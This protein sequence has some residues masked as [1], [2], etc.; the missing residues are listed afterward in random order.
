MALGLPRRGSPPQSSTQSP[1]RCRERSKQA[2]KWWYRLGCFVILDD[3][4]RRSR[5]QKIKTKNYAEM[6]KQEEHQLFPCPLAPT[7]NSIIG[8]KGFEK[9]QTTH[10]LRRCCSPTTKIPQS[11]GLH[12]PFSL[13]S[14][15]TAALSHLPARHGSMREW[16]VPRTI[17]LDAHFIIQKRMRASLPVDGMRTR[18]G[19]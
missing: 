3:R 8:D 2:R 17:M 9:G 16:V 13:I 1:L 19:F 11:A 12:R 5:Q 14:M 4:R 7:G 6:G 10:A 18:Y 15:T